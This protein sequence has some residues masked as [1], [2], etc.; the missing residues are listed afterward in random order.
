MGNVPNKEL[1][2]HTVVNLHS[3]I[4]DCKGK[5][6]AGLAKVKRIRK[7]LEKGT[8]VGGAPAFFRD[9]EER[10]GFGLDPDK[11]IYLCPECEKGGITFND[12]GSLTPCKF[13]ENEDDD[14]CGFDGPYEPEE[15]DII[16]YQRRGRKEL[17]RVYVPLRE[18]HIC[19]V[20]WP[21]ILLPIL[22]GERKVAKDDL[23]EV[24]CRD[25]G[26]GLSDQFDK[27]TGANDPDP[28]LAEE[29]EEK[30]KEEKPEPKLVENEVPK[31]EMPTEGAATAL[32]EAA[33][34]D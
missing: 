30:K 22:Q 23:V 25:L 21:D 4:A 5:G 33:K 24:I 31:A 34:G 12:D 18:K 28:I 27:V 29:E 15:D 19:G 32:A 6:T 11:P 8:L 10:A 17:K 26:E 2:F 3:I 1:R 16:G 13:R 9:A 14:P 20:I 7:L